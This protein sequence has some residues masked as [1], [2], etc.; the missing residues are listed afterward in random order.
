MQLLPPQYKLCARLVVELRG[1]VEALGFG[2][3]IAGYL[4]S[5]A[6]RLDD[7]SG[8]QSK[9]RFTYLFPCGLHTHNALLVYRELQ[10]C[11]RAARQN[12]TICWLSARAEISALVLFP[13]LAPSNQG[14]P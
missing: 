7:G 3:G 5:A 10:H 2:Q 13:T 4:A 9:F 6:V 11:N 8:C 1:D 12:S 14:R